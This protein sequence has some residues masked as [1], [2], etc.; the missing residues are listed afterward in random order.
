MSSNKYNIRIYNNDDYDRVV[1]LWKTAFPDEPP[2]NDPVILIKRKLTVQPELF[3]VCCQ[4]EK[5][6]GAVM[7]GFDGVRGWIYHLAVHPEYRRKGIA[8]QLMRTAANSLKGK[9]CPK[10]NLQV[11]STNLEVIGFYRSIGFN[12]EDRVSM[13]MR[14]F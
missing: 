10:I 1:K 14:L 12:I 5:I 4:E 11:R 13:G 2:H 8:T 7:A 6:V 9:G 3:F